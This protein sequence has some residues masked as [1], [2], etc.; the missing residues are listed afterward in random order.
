MK[1]GM[2]MFLA[3]VLAFMPLMSASANATEVT[4]AEPIFSKPTVSA[5]FTDDCVMLVMTNEASLS[6]LN[7]GV[8]DFSEID[9]KSVTNLSESKTKK[10]WKCNYQAKLL[11]RLAEAPAQ[12][13][14]QAIL[15]LL[16]WKALT[17]FCVLN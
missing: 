4:S 8:S 15:M 13:H 12:M 10:R 16:T 7:Y 2:L 3:V 11:R 6:K 1:K 5:N 17:R 9:C 14:Y